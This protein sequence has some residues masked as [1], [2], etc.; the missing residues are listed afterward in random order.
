MLGRGGNAEVYLGIN[1]STGKL[2]AVKRVALPSPSSPAASPSKDSKSNRLLRRKYEALRDEINILSSAVHPNIVQY[3][4]TSQTAQHLHILL[5]FVPGGSIRKL[6]DTFGP[7]SDAVCKTYLKQILSGLLYLHNEKQFVHGDLKGAN[8]LVTDKG[9]CKITDFGTTTAIQKYNV[10]DKDSSSKKGNAT[11]D[12]A[13]SS[14]SSSSK[15][16]SSSSSS[17]RKDEEGNGSSSKETPSTNTVIHGTLLWMAPE[18][19]G[20][21]LHASPSPASNTASAQKTGGGGGDGANNDSGGGSS[22]RY[23]TFSSDMW[24][25]GCTLIE[26]TSARHPWFEYDFDTQDQIAYLLM[27]VEESPEIPET[28][29]D[30]VLRGVMEACLHLDPKA[31]PTATKLLEI[32]L[33]DE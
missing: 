27:H 25:L 12:L 1:L 4:G 32:L 19:L 28:V 31:R 11:K 13:P 21:Q 23:P 6:L 7:L 2:I 33:K 26:M 29:Q 16:A 9:D 15:T 20:N 8:I 22:S 14:S 24:S 3:H 5:E 18:L 10:S 30:P 17:S